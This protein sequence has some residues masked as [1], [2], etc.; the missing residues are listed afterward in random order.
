MHDCTSDNVTMNITEG[1]SYLFGTGAMQDDY[2]RLLDTEP[3]GSVFRTA[4]A[5]YL[6]MMNGRHEDLGEIDQDRYE[7]WRKDVERLDTSEARSVGLFLRDLR[8][9]AWDP[10]FCFKPSRRCLERML[11]QA[12]EYARAQ[13]IEVD[14]SADKPEFAENTYWNGR[15]KYQREFHRLSNRLIPPNC[16]K[17]NTKH[18]EVLRLVA[19]LYYEV[20]ANGGRNIDRDADLQAALEFLLAHDI[21][22]LSHQRRRALHDRLFNIGAVYE[23]RVG[24]QMP[25]DPGLTAVELESLER[26]M[27][28]AVLQAME[29]ENAKVEGEVSAEPAEPEP[30]T[31]WAGTGK[32][33]ATLDRL[34]GADGLGTGLMPFDEGLDLLV[35]RR[36]YRRAHEKSQTGD[37]RKIE[38]DEV[39][40]MRAVFRVSDSW[41]ATSVRNDLYEGVLGRIGF[42]HLED[43][44]DAAILR[45]DK[46]LQARLEEGVQDVESAA[47]LVDPTSVED[48]K[49]FV[50]DVED[51]NTAA[52][53]EQVLALARARG[54]LALQDLVEQQLSGVRDLKD[55]LEPTMWGEFS[56]AKREAETGTCR[57]SSNLQDCRQHAGAPESR[58]P[59]GFPQEPAQETPTASEQMLEEAED[60][61][62]EAVGAFAAV[63]E[64]GTGVPG[65][66]LRGIGEHQDVLRRL[67]GDTDLDSY[68]E[69]RD[70][71]LSW[72]FYQRLHI[73]DE[74]SAPLFP[75]EAAALSTIGRRAGLPIDRVLDHSGEW[76]HLNGDDL[77]LL[78]KI[79]DAAI[80]RAEK[81]KTLPK[82]TSP[83]GL[84]EPAAALADL[85]ALKHDR[86]PG[87]RRIVNRMPLAGSWPWAKAAAVACLLLAVL[88]MAAG[89]A[90]A[91]PV[92]VIATVL[93][94]MTSPPP[95]MQTIPPETPSTCQLSLEVVLGTPLTDV[96][97]D[98]GMFTKA[99][100]VPPFVGAVGFVVGAS[101]VAF[102][103][104]FAGAGSFDG[105]FFVRETGAGCSG[106][107]TLLISSQ[108]TSYTQG[109][110]AVVSVSNAS[111]NGEVMTG[112]K[113]RVVATETM[114]P[115]TYDAIASTSFSETSSSQITLSVLLGI[116]GIFTDGFES[117]DTTAWDTTY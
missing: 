27:D 5:V 16:Q 66:Y 97:P 67:F 18:G 59:S 19:G 38:S 29:A 24:R 50:K 99:E 22:F 33:Q 80:L 100:V 70:L 103:S 77:L 72:Q 23:N 58:R 20:H 73:V 3:Q 42:E 54:A 71:Q 113:I 60:S 65:S 112:E 62:A 37:L 43:A 41:K 2:E 13:A 83:T 115:F 61:F 101:V 108:S 117:G 90:S 34:L 74:D 89:Q 76:W 45:A 94:G 51:Y 75:G 44:L 40:A 69:G 79:M 36:L 84:R 91:Q 31:Y 78:E 7:R 9:P 86:I 12:I 88:G 98:G 6:A 87:L 32:H 111:V 52:E 102:D 4:N 1:E 110:N 63:T 39:S 105:H 114:I 82:S 104:G 93:Q 49:S 11:T 25:V 85:V 26:V 57:S 53:G 64:G 10:E 55:E 106:T 46:A 17:A 8:D 68:Q 35:V 21:A 28:A 96:D 81:W 116:G 92:G 48:I 14:G 95:S 107:A 15:G 109:V 56:R 30:G 47:S